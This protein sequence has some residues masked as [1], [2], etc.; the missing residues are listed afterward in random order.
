[1]N[2]RLRWLAPRF[3]SR[4]KGVYGEV[5][6][7]IVPVLGRRG[8]CVCCVILIYVSLYVCCIYLLVYLSLCLTLP[9]CIFLYSLSEQNMF[10]C[11]LWTCVIRK[12]WSW[13]G[14]L[15]LVL[16]CLR[17]GGGINFRVSPPLV[18]PL[19]RPSVVTFSLDSWHFTAC[20][21][22][23]EMYAVLF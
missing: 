8:N 19:P 2:G 3:K 16:V 9:A 6:G 23:P 21:R 4:K 18:L 10:V 1:M 15:E 17:V 7:R 22:D 13:Q 11:L 20:S 14:E 5:G 12:S